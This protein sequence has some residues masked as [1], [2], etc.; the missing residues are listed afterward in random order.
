MPFTSLL[1]VN[2]SI[3]NSISNED[4]LKIEHAKTGRSRCRKC[5]ETIEKN[6]LRV[7]MKAWIM[8]RNSIT[9]QH[10]ECFISNIK[11]LL[12]LDSL[13]KSFNR[14]IGFFLAMLIFNKSD[15]FI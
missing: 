11:N 4:I 6:E 9:W 15:Q 13:I 14:G 7:G 12:F 3:S 5:L 1:V 8:G 2:C 10:Q